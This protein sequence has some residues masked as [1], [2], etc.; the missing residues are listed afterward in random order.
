MC[1]VTLRGGHCLAVFEPSQLSTTAWYLYYAWGR[2]EHVLWPRL[3]LDGPGDPVRLS[4]A[5]PF[6]KTNEVGEVVLCFLAQLPISCIDI[7]RGQ[8]LEVFA[9]AGTACG[10]SGYQTSMFYFF[11]S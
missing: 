7:G 6:G 9:Y 5:R 1:A 11:L 2:T 8:R 10:S 4:Q 3:T